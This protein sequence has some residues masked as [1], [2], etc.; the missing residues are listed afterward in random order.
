MYLTKSK[1]FCDIMVYVRAFVSFVTHGDQVI[2]RKL[3]PRHVLSL[4]DFQ[5]HVLALV[6]RLHIC[7]HPPVIVSDFSTPPFRRRPNVCLFVGSSWAL[8]LMR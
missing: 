2:S 5:L 7:V 8:A 4:P 6:A 1:W 3:R